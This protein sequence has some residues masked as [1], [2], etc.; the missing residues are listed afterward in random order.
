MTLT[1]PLQGYTKL[2]SLI[3]AHPDLAIYRRFGK[4]NAKNL[5]YLQAELVVLE[6]R[7]EECVKKD[8]ESGDQDRVLFDRDWQSL[9]ESATVNG[10][11][12]GGSEKSEQ[13]ETVSKIKEKLREYNEALLLQT[14]LAKQ[15]APIERD[16]TFLQNWMKR[17]TM[18]CVYLLGYDRDVWTKT[19]REELVVVRSNDGHTFAARIIGDWV[20]YWA[21]RLTRRKPKRTADSNYTNTIAYS[22]EKLEV[23]SAAVGIICS[24]A[25]PVLA[26][27]LLYAVNS[28]ARRLAIIAVFTPLFSTI[29]IICSPGRSIE[30]CAATAAFAAVQVVFVGTTSA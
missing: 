7:L 19:P 13:W 12:V 4:L 26:I 3:G 16:L 22:D 1:Q 8:Q 27:V 24:F 9:A 20:A 25:L 18:G 17:T 30:I 5:L 21:Y 14:M 15:P 23:I 6:R 11:N 29:L 28:M 10:G 2:A